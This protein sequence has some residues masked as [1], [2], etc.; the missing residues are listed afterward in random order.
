[1]RAHFGDVAAVE[2][3]DAVRTLDGGEAVRDDEARSAL[4]QA[5]HGLLNADL[6]AGVDVGGRLV[7]DQHRNIGKHG[8]RDGQQLLLTL[9]NARTVIGQH[10]LIAVGKRFDEG[11]DLR[12]LCR[13]DDLLLGRALLAVGDVVKDRAAE[14]PRF[15]QYHGVR[16]AQTVAGDIADIVSVDGDRARLRIVEAHEQI[17]DRRFAGTRRTDDRDH[18]A[19]CDIQRQ[20][21]DDDAVLGV[22]EAD[23]VKLDLT[24]G[25]GQNHGIFGIGLL[26]RLVQQTEHTL[27]RGTCRLQLGKDVCHFVDGT[28]EAAA[29][30]DKRGNVA[31]RHAPEHIQHRAEHGNERQRQVVDEVDGRTDDAALIVRLVV[32]VDGVCVVSVKT[33][34]D[35]RFAVVRLDRLL[36]RQHLLGIA[37]ERTEHGGTAAEERLYLLGT[38]TG[39]ED[40]HRHGEA[41]DQQKQRRDLHH[42]NQRADD[43]DGAGADLNDV[44]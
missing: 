42:H 27:R 33:V 3:E 37:V 17:D 8:A 24:A 16:R 38:V 14:Q 25:I 1:M 5:D 19:G 6:G 11:M 32:G 9:G 34:D 31:Q 4:H 12:R 39:K 23:M 30:L 26:G 40:R 41:E 35:D 43:G 29:V 36:T 22:A 20:I 21:A 18:L 7:E 10:R 44:V 2:D 15:L 28:G 13:R